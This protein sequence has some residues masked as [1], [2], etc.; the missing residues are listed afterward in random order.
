MKPLQSTFGTML[1]GNANLAGSMSNLPSSSK[2]ALSLGSG[3]AIAIVAYLDSAIC[4]ETPQPP[5]GPPSPS[6]RLLQELGTL[7]PLGR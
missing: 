7:A 2:V 3:G 6:S 4:D 5:V 1:I